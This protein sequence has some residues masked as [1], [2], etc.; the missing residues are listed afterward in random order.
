MRQIFLNKKLKANTLPEVLISLAIISFA[1]A[2]GI[3]IYLNV[4]NSTRPFLKLKA[5][6]LCKSELRQSI[7]QRDFFDNSKVVNDLNIVKKV[8]RLDQYSD[9][10][11][12]TIKVSDSNGKELSKLN[13][14]VYA[15]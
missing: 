4:Q 11:V 10:V 8:S 6:D 5:N 15:Q 1:S 2:L 13:Q 14:I 9:C 3:T 7:K 12:V